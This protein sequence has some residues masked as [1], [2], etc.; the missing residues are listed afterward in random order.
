MKL[1]IFIL[2]NLKNIIFFYKGKNR[3]M[4]DLKKIYFIYAQKGEQNNI[5]SFDTNKKIKNI[6]EIEK[7]ILDNFIQILYCIEISAD[8]RENQ[9]KINLIDNMGEYYYSFIPLNTLELLGKENVDTDEIVIFNLQFMNYQSKEENKLNQYILPYAQQFYIFENKFKDSD[10]KLI[11]LYSSA[12]T[13]IL[14][15]SN[16]K[17][18]LI[19]Y[20]FF[21]LFDERKYNDEP[22]L[23]EVLKYFFENID[24]ILIKTEYTK[25]LDIGKEKLDLLSNPNIRAKLIRLSGAKE[26]N[27]DLFLSYYYIHY[28]KKLFITY[29][30]NDKYKDSIKNTLIT[31][32]KI[33]G[34]FTSEIIN[35]ELMDEA[36]D[37]PQLVSLMELYPNI[38]E[39]FKI[40][41]N[42]TIFLKF[43]NF[44]Q[45]NRK[46]V[47]PMLILKPN[48]NDDIEKL[49]K[50]FKKVYKLFEKEKVYPIIL[51]E[52]FF[53]EYY[54]C[55]EANDEDFNK[56]IIIIDM[57]NLYN[58]NN[59]K[60]IEVDKVLKRHFE[61]GISLL[62]K[63]KLINQDFLKFIKLYEDK[64][65]NEELI[66][67]FPNGIQFDEKNNVF[68]EDILNDTYHYLRGFLGYNYPGVFKKIFERFN[69]PKE[70][71]PLK[72]W[73]INDSTP[74]IIIKIFMLTIQRIWLNNPENN[75]F[76]LENLFSRVFS[77]ASLHTDNYFNVIQTLEE[78]IEPEKLMAIYSN[79]LLKNFSIKNNFK[80]HII[81]FI[82][83][84]DNFTP[85]YLWYLLCTCDLRDEK[86]E[87]LSK[88]L[89][90]Q[91]AVKYSDFIN[92]PKKNCE[93]ILLFTKLKNNDYIPGDFEESDYY[94]CSMASK[95]QLEKNTFKDASNM[96][97][98]LDKILKLL[99]DFFVESE[100]ELDQ[101]EINITIFKDKVEH[102]KKYYESLKTIQKFW[103]AFLPEEKKNDLINLKESIKK[104][105]NEKLEN[106][107]NVINSNQDILNFL[108]EAEEGAEFI[109]SIFF[110]EIYNKEKGKFKEKE[111]LRY[112]VSINKFKQIIKLGENNDLNSLK[113]EMKNNIINAA[114]KNE[115][116]LNGELEFIKK[117]F[118]FSENEKYKK[119]NI[120]SIKNNIQNF[121]KIRRNEEIIPEPD[122]DNDDNINENNI[123]EEQ[124]EENIQNENILEKDKLINGIKYIS[125][126]LL[127]NSYLFENNQENILYSSF[128]DFYE[129]LYGIGI[130]LGKLSKQEITNLIISNSNKF[131]YIGKNLGIIDDNKNNKSL[132]DILFLQQFNFIIHIIEIYKKSTKINYVKAFASVK[133]MFENN[134]QNKFDEEELDNLMGVLKEFIPN[135]ETNYIYIE[136]FL[137]NLEKK[138]KK[139]LV[140]YMLDK[141]NDKLYE[142][143][144][145]IFDNIFSQDINK[146]IAFR[147]IEENANYFEF[148]SEVIDEIKIIYKKNKDI[149]LGEMI[150]FYFENKMMNELN[151][152][153]KEINKFIEKNFENFRTYLDFFEKKYKDNNIENND[154]FLSLIYILAFV[155][156]YVYE[157]IK[158]IQE[159]NLIGEQEFL[160]HNILKFSE[161]NSQNYPLRFSLKLYVFKL[162]IYYN[163]NYST[164]NNF[165]ESYHID[166]LKNRLNSNGKDFGFD[167]L[168]IP[169]QLNT[170]NNV[171]NSIV[172][173]F[174]KSREIF[175]DIEIKEEIKNNIDILYCLLA[176]FQFSRYYNK[177]YF[178]LTE[179]TK[180]KKY[181]SEIK[182][183]ILQKEGEIIEN[184]FGYFIDLIPNKVYK[185]FDVF[186]YDQLLS[187]LISAR[188]IINIISSKS[189]NSLFYN[190]LTKSKETINNNKIFFNEYYLKKFDAKINSNR[191]I[192]CLTYTMINY[193]IF[194]HLY[195]G[196]NLDL[197]KAD[198]LKNI[199]SLKEL[200]GKDEKYVSDYLLD[201]IFE[202]F[203]LIKNT[204]LPLI[205]IYNII[206]FMDFIFK[207]IYQQLI[208]FQSGDDEK[209]IK[210]NEQSIDAALNNIINDYSKAVNKYYSFENAPVNENNNNNKDEIIKEVTTDSGNKDEI[211]DIISENPLFY[212]NKE[213]MNR[214]YPLLSYFTYSNYT[215]LNDDFQN[216]FFYFNNNSTDYP[217]ISSV[218]SGDEIFEII[219]YLPKLNKFIN[220]IHDE[221]NMRYTENE[222]QVK[223]IKE[224]FYDKINEDL[225]NFNNF[226]EKNK[227]L[228]DQ[229]KKISNDSKLSE[230]INL[231]GSSVNYVYKIIIDKYN[232]FLSKM[233]YINIKIFDK[234]LIQEAKENDYNINSVIKGEDKITL[235][236]KLDEL[237][238]LYSKRARKI[239]GKINVYD[240]GKI[241]YNFTV[242][243]NK[244]EEQFIF[245]K[246]RFSEV[247]RLF[248]FSSE[249]FEQEADIIKKFSNIYPQKKINE[250][251]KTNMEK[252]I[253]TIQK[254]NDDNVLNLFYELFF[255]FKYITKNAQN[256]K[257]KN[258]KDLIKYLELKQYEFT[259]MNSAIS[260]LTGSLSLNSI[261][262]FYEIV[263]KEAFNNLTINIGK[264]LSADEIIIDQEIEKN[265]EKCL[266]DNKTITTNI[267]ISA[268][269]KYILRNIKDKTEDKHLFNINDLEH[270]KDLWDITIFSTK[271]FKGE[272]KK[273]VE[274]DGEQKNIVKYLYSKIYSIEIKNEQE[275]E[276]IPDPE[277]IFD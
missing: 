185:D 81:E 268:M 173:K 126:E 113:E 239:N 207:E 86:I 141:K 205:G 143:M 79:M 228:F 144:F 202:S 24:K 142:D 151:K 198:D 157:I 174:F 128:F 166:D 32:R 53:V 183:Q 88:Y 110:M 191:N 102:G 6:K 208:I 42:E 264:K 73:I 153:Q 147:N 62:K 112:K 121:I 91:L 259:Q 105:E 186:S 248:I 236:E 190:L 1:S 206:I 15:K 23:K 258:E 276:P 131:Y 274:L 57:V 180:I 98:N 272:F 219:E 159:S 48:I 45:I 19:I 85:L 72:N 263:E 44:K 122:N 229:N 87:L 124:P 255:I 210:N 241:I 83:S 2:L 93:K 118:N 55:F 160:F 273:L 59:K 234:V 28:K 4:D 127:Y 199:I 152:K 75:M 176:N 8:N 51:K 130:N 58:S 184:I 40:L 227:Q 38:V 46:S 123:I 9:V 242:I 188:F 257:F 216:Q 230:I 10:E 27:I 115:N 209:E 212:N 7:N 133:N 154:S 106:I 182:E 250:E 39:V 100:N 136:I 116:L 204:L 240:G 37:V 101:V 135:Y 211:L 150:F 277:A 155:K 231:K 265:I 17:F 179:Y 64:S 47:N 256:F 16:Q 107:E 22:R 92:F 31:H 65:D 139:D 161:A 203:I 193:L 3:K 56:C 95:N 12:I 171:Y 49:Q 145:P 14:L 5:L 89:N 125:E 218:L 249:I 78:K 220:H 262:Y 214:K 41:T 244:L 243:E 134:R 163:G 77:S 117:Y 33:F 114:T 94:K 63:K 215:V 189:E 175:D 71:L 271:D 80:I 251:N 13:Q 178:S 18:D 261:L 252:Y 146:K 149:N 25:K 168:F 194:S 165:M 266:K 245:G 54:K 66:K 129:K 196:L 26:E 223:T 138:N 90:Y 233:K 99:R 68:T 201:K 170:D 222:I 156:C 61:K 96:N 21:K 269:K 137:M 111:M 253:K 84:Y 267:I 69:L 74:P 76:G 60:K 67:Y 221:L 224:V 226:I 217:L 36:E 104:F 235:K 195:F 43:I 70:L 237:I 270:K 35:S 29:I 119:F 200:E 260:Q 192:N 247:Q 162:L 108:K 120:K 213:L 167:F 197:L 169:L 187:I 164:I 20:I 103:E 254:K 172:K 82:K 158:I 275:P 109:D 132:D 181:Y 50:Y 148:I 11:N 225:S 177:N 140:K 97:I 30:N 34:D 232:K 238:L 52:N 246:K